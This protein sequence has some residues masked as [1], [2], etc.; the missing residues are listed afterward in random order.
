MCSSWTLKNSG[1]NTVVD[2]PIP[3][4]CHIEYAGNWY[5]YT[6]PVSV[7]TSD[8]KIESGKE[9]VQHVKVTTDKWWQFVP[10]WTDKGGG[11]NEA[12]VLELKPGKHKVRV[13]YP[14]SGKDALRVVSQQVEIEVGDPVKKN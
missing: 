13:S 2:A 8:V 14:L 1:K 6:A 10:P 11:T 7:V 5:T 3:F 9:Y 4:H 12:K